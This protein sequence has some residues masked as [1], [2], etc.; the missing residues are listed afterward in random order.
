M[1]AT[2]EILK[3]KVPLI[4]DV[5]PLIDSLTAALDEVIDNILLSLT[6]HHAAALHGV[7][8]LNKYYTKTNDSIIYCIAMSM[9]LF[10][11]N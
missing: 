4:H 2:K 10:S 6:V 8:L 7:L 3:C 5:I 11:K 1:F 9:F